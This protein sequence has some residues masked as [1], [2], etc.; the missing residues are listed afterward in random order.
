MQSGQMVSISLKPMK[1]FSFSTTFVAGHSVHFNVTGSFGLWQEQPCL[2]VA[3]HFTHL[4]D[5]N[6]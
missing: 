6:R 5:S 4:N 2:R 1:D 3:P